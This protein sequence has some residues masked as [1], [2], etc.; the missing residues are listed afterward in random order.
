M[1]FYIRLWRKYI[2]DDDKIGMILYLVTESLL[3]YMSETT[4]FARWIIDLI[5]CMT[6]DNNMY[7][8]FILL[9]NML[10]DLQPIFMSWK[11]SAKERSNSW[12]IW[13]CIWKAGMMRGGVNCTAGR[14]QL[15]L[16]ACLGKYF[17]D[18]TL[19]YFFLFIW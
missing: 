5:F 8:P 16:V 15:V 6:K 19:F 2:T 1:N 13:K 4:L 17:V 18:V 9:L 7:L 14:M 12:D 11:M 3:Q 10:L